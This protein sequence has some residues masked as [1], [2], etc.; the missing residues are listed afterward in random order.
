MTAPSPK[1]TQR[2]ALE[3]VPVAG[4]GFAVEGEPGRVASTLTLLQER[5]AVTANE[6]LA[7]LYGLDRHGYVEYGTSLGWCWL[8]PEGEQRLADLRRS[9]V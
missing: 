2:Q 6:A 8:T 9:D 4:A 5:Y 1:I 7:K 3:A